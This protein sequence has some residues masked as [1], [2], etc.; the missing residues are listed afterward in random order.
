MY[1]YKWHCCQPFLLITSKTRQNINGTLL[2]LSLPAMRYNGVPHACLTRL[3]GKYLSIK[4]STNGTF[5]IFSL[6]KI[7]SYLLTFQQSRILSAAAWLHLLPCNILQ[8]GE[9][10]ALNAVGITTD[11]NFRKKL[12]AWIFLDAFQIFSLSSNH[13]YSKVICLLIDTAL[14][15]V[16]SMV[17]INSEV[18]R[19]FQDI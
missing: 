7:K 4:L 8:L 9:V 6:T 17:F 1:Y 11:P 13:T 2:K 19:A 16:K 18:I 5:L 12:P 3:K 15:P 10:H 14:S